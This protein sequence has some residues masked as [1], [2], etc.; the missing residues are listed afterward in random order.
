MQLT[1]VRVL[2]AIYEPDFLGFS[3]GFRPERSAHDALDALVV[4]IDSSVR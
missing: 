2:N 4:G 1:V 3:Y